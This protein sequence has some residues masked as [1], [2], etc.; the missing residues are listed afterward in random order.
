VYLVLAAD[1][2]N[3]LAVNQ[4]KFEQPDFLLGGVLA[5]RAGGL[6]VFWIYGRVCCPAIA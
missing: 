3:R 1:G 2:R 6:V 4:M 5:G